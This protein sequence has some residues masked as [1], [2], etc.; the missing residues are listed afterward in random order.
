MTIATRQVEVHG[1]RINYRCYTPREP[2]GVGRDAD[3]VVLVHGIAGSGRTWVPV[4]EELA[5]RRF[6]R[7]VIAPDLPGHGESDTP[8]G[9]YSVGALAS[10]LRDL[11]GLLGHQRVTIVGH[12]L[13]GGVAMQFAYL[14]PERCGR[15]VLVASGGLGRSVSPLIR[16]SN[17][18]GAGSVLALCLNDSVSRFLIRHSKRWRVEVRELAAHLASL[19]NPARRAAYLQVVRS[20]TDIHGQRANATDRLYLAEAIPSLIIWGDRDPIIPVAHG[21]RAAE[22]MPNS[23]LEIIDGVGHFPHCA[24]PQRFVDE[25]MTFLQ[26]TEP[27]ELNSDELVDLLRRRP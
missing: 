15:L 26:A 2:A 5:A 16:M 22:L 9:D 4:L 3:P 27:A 12:S 1:H 24:D 13:G 11:G 17:L 21:K 25:L 8:R 6:R 20:S 14:F 10:V 7:E 19:S 18:P 23:H